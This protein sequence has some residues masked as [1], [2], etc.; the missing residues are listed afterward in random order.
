MKLMDEY[1]KHEKIEELKQIKA[2]IQREADIIKHNE[3][4]KAYGM[5]IAI[6]Y[7]DEHIEKLK[8]D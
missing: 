2:E 6:E 7:I 8:E 4:L 5:E 3:R 1:I